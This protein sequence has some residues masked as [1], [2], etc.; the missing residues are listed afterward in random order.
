M[1]LAVIA[2]HDW[3]ITALLLIWAKVVHDPDHVFGRKALN[4]VLYNWPFIRQ[5]HRRRFA[6]RHFH[7]PFCITALCIG[8]KHDPSHVHHDTIYDLDHVWKVKNG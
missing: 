5:G 6:M 7:V 8:R 4:V 2:V 1:F 3:I